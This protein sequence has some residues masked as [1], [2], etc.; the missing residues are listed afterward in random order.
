MSQIS[1][2]FL[3]LKI[4]VETKAVLRKVASAHRVLAEFKGIL[5]SIPNQTILLETLTLR[6][7]RE[8]A[9]TSP[10]IIEAL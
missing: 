6:E 7:A 9:V 2:A 4:D 1:I 10:Q 3:P 5:T 8:S